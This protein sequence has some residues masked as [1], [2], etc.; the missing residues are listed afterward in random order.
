MPTPL[1]G[2]GTID[3]RMRALFNR[4]RD[5]WQLLTIWRTDNR[6]RTIAWMLGKIATN[7][8]NHDITGGFGPDGYVWVGRR[9]ENSRK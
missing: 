1:A 5:A 6:V 8:K 2:G 9:C 3:F 4:G 7:S